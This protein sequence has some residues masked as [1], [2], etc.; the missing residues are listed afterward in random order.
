LR[1]TCCFA[2]AGALLACTKQNPAYVGDG[3]DAGP[4]AAIPDAGLSPDHAVSPEVAAD[5][6]AL[7]PDVGSPGPD[8][9]SPDTAGDLAADRPA[10]APAG[11]SR[12]GFETSAEGWHDLRDAFYH[13]P[14]TAVARSTAHAFEGQSALEISVDTMN[15]YTTPTIGVMISQAI[16]AGTRITYHLWFPGNGSIEAVQPYVLYDKRG[17]NIPQ[18]GGIDPVLSTSALTPNA[19]NTVT[20]VVP[21]DIVGKV[22][23]VGME[24]RTFGN[25]RV[26]VY[27]DAVTW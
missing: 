20:H 27:M 19:W 18:W 7:S 8:L 4:A 25:Q 6:V 21:D 12:Y 1:L 3:L 24:W 23:E 9:A 13:Q 17:S 22:Y 16:P 11:A 14:T 10:D 15:G 26:K 5:A 2:L